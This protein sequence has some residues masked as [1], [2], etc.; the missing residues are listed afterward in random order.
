MLLGFIA[1]TFRT[2][3]LDPIDKPPSL[4]KTITR[5]LD[6]ICLYM[7]ENSP[8]VHQACGK[9]FVDIFNYCAPNKT[10]RKTVSLMFYERLDSVI[11]GGSDIIA[12]KAACFTLCQFTKNMIDNKLDVLCEFFCP[13]II[14]LFI[15]TR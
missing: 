5:V 14:T 15:K 12:Q 1:N 6:Q 2:N 13:K 7:K 4:I 10:E 11:L 9:S 8:L 3:M